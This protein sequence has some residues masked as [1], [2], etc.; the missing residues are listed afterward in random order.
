MRLRWIIVA[1]VVG[2]AAFHAAGFR[3]GA[4]RLTAQRLGM[5]P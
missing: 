1:G 3:A 5:G 4:A 2:T